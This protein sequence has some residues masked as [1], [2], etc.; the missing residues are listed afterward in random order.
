MIFIVTMVL[1]SLAESFCG[2]V[3]FARGKTCL[4]Y[5]EADQVQLLNTALSGVTPLAL[6]LFTLNFVNGV[7]D[8]KS[9]KLE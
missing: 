2:Q 7:N 1:F 6:G 8:K 9:E 5:T 3:H 4:K